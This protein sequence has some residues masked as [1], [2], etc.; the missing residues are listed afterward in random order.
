MHK[1]FL[2]KCF[3][4][5][6]FI[7]MFSVTAFAENIDVS[8][9]KYHVIV[10]NKYMYASNSPLMALNGDKNDGRFSGF[11]SEKEMA[12]IQIV[13]GD[14]TLN[15]SRW[16]LRD[17]YGVMGAGRACGFGTT[18]DGVYPV[19]NITYLDFDLKLY[20]GDGSVFFYPETIQTQVM[21]VMEVQLVEKILVAVKQ[22]AIIVVSSLALLMALKTLAPRLRTY[23]KGHLKA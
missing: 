14:G 18:S 13:D 23:L 11:I 21:K 3:V 20:K 8:K 9:Y 12:V 16:R 15:G 22:V 5:A 1:K 6:F 7:S 17:G 2:S 19:G 4:I 10:F